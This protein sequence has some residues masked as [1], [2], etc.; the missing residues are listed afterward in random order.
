[1][2]NTDGVRSGLCSCK[3]GLDNGDIDGDEGLDVRKVI[4]LSL[5]ATTLAVVEREDGL[6]LLHFWSINA[7]NCFRDLSY[8][9]L[10]GKIP[11]FLADMPLLKVLN[12]DGNNFTGS[13]PQALL[14][15]NGS[16]LTLSVGENPHLCVSPCGTKKSNKN[17]YIV[18]VSIISVLYSIFCPCFL[19][20]GEWVYEMRERKLRIDV[21]G[22]STAE[23]SCLKAVTS[24]GAPS[25]TTEI[26]RMAARAVSGK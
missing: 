20:Y 21:Y 19:F 5:V 7:S 17:M 24:R 12:L 9:N 22:S 26:V 15:K 10:S 13:V 3:S 25:C 2:V 18:P 6:F 1:M 14:S 8:N 23:Q 11:A 4:A 16:T